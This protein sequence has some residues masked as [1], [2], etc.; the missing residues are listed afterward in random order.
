[1]LQMKSK[2]EQHYH[3]ITLANINML[4]VK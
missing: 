1:L 2:C 4:E 3:F